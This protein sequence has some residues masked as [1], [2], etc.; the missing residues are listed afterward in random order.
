M[1]SSDYLF[2]NVDTQIDF[3]SP[4]GK[5]YVQGAELLK[6]IWKKITRLIK[7]IEPGVFQSLN[8]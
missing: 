7:I 6:P 4:K 3:V 5:L 8:E 1:Q 2:W